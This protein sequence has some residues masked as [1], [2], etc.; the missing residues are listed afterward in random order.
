MQIQ[1]SAEAIKQIRVFADPLVVPFLLWIGRRM[2]KKSRETLHAVITE[3]ANRIRTELI[4]HIDV[5]LEEHL[6]CD[7][8]QF[9]ALRK[10][11][12]LEPM[13]EET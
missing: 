7:R 8:E 5:K 9:G 4:A 6:K 11:M 13:R 10:A 12:G 1:I 2:L 3:N